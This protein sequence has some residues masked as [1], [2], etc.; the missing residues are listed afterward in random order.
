MGSQK[1]MG[2]EKITGPQKL[3][4]RKNLKTARPEASYSKPIRTPLIALC[5]GVFGK[6]ASL[7]ILAYLISN[8]WL[9][10]QTI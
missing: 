10:G 5:Y 3:W 8:R 2:S 4:A 9:S 6:V 1:I 7:N